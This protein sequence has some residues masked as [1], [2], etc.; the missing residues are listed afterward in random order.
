MA[1]SAAQDMLSFEGVTLHCN[2]STARLVEEALRR[3]EGVLAANGALACDTGERTGR[4]PNDKFLEDTPGVHDSISWGSVNRPITP[5]LFSELE[6][7]AHAHLSSR[8]ELYRFDGY[9]GADENYRLKVSVVTEEAWH[10][11][12]ASTLFIKASAEDQAEAMTDAMLAYE[13]SIQLDARVTAMSDSELGEDGASAMTDLLIQLHA[14]LDGDI[15]TG[16]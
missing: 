3:G 7:R 11:L 9:A 2:L 6:S 8:D 14:S 12:F 1:M 16:E 15:E 5:E 4:S 13:S 10:S